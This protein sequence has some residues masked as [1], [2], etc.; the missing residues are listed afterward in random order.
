MPKIQNKEP[1]EESP[2]MNRNSVKST[3]N[4]DRLE[5]A[6]FT[7]IR[8]LDD[9]GTSPVRII[10]YAVIVII[11]GVGAAIVVRNLIANN[12]VDNDQQ[13][14]QAQDNDEPSQEEFVVLSLTPK[15][16]SSANNLASNEDYV[17]SS[18]VTLGDATL[19]MTNVE[20]NKIEYTRFTTFARTTFV[21]TGNNQKLP[22][23]NITYSAANDA[24]TVQFIGLENIN[25]SLKD[26]V[27]INDIV[28]DISFDES[29]SSFTLK[30]S[31]DSK[32]R[33]AQDLGSLLIDVKTVDELSKPDT[34]TPVANDDEEE[35]EPETPVAPPSSDP[36]KP[37]APHYENAFSQNKQYISSSVTGNTLG[38]N[39]FWIWDESTFFEFSL[40]QT[41]AKGD[42]HIPNATAYYKDEDSK[43]YLY[44]EIEN[45]SS[46][47]FSQTQ[48]RTIENLIETTGATIAPSQVNFVKVDLVS[49]SGG[50]AVYRIEVKHKSDFRLLTQETYD[51][52][53]QIVS[54]Q[55]KD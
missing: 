36:S 53:T 50:K 18:I 6:R 38:F 22:K 15:A 42:N 7:D 8:D 45:L 39:N 21:L 14:E 49:F 28:K 20:L 10:I 43:T 1:L 40:G 23:T 52:T 31:K 48:S 2:L 27:I 46:A 47:P 17:D 26:T 25:E 29:D 4:P 9:D 34:Q 54:L 12:Q 51:G 33:V 55:I 5:H 3:I 32:F 30:F 44:L 37:S 11:V 35:E 13:T 16:D 24:L 19:D 41:N